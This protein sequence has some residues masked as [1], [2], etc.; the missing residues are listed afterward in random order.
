MLDKLFLKGYKVLLG[1]FF[2]LGIESLIHG[3]IVGDFSHIRL[4]ITMFTMS[5]LIFLYKNWI[6]SKE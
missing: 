4:S 6:K 1:L 2:I 3:F 5:L